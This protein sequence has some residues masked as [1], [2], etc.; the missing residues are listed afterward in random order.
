MSGTTDPMDLIAIDLSNT[1]VNKKVDA[2]T[3][4]DWKKYKYNVI[5]VPGFTPK[6]AK[7][8]DPMD[9][10]EVARV[11][12]AKQALEQ[13]EAPFILVSGGNCHPNGTK[14]NEATEMK[15]WL[16]Y[17]GH[18]PED[19][20]IVEPAAQHSTTNLRNAGR[21]MLNHCMTKALI[22]TTGSQH[23]YFSHPGP[24]SY[25][26]RCVHGSMHCR[27][28]GLGAVKGSREIVY[29]PSQDV[30]QKGKDRLDP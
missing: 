10:Q 7:E 9:P 22:V 16:I 19:R 21:Y 3:E 20:I 5:I 1:E 14:K 6:H 11:K 8:D 24:S 4:E 30:T 12:A 2:F 13:G 28:G 27:I 29:T 15:R 18:L 23:F 17:Y 25:F 26:F